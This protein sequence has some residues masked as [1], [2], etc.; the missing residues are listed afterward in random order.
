[1][2]HDLHLKIADFGLSERDYNLLL[3]GSRTAKSETTVQPIAWLPYEVLRNKDKVY[4]SDVWSFGVYMWEVFEFGYGNPYAHMK[5]QGTLE[6]D[7]LI[8][9][10][11]DGNRLAMPE[12]CPDEVFQLMK[13]CWELDPKQR[14][15]FQNL[16]ERLE[17]LAYKIAKKE[18]S[19]IYRQSQTETEYT[20]V[21]SPKSL[22]TQETQLSYAGLHKEFEW[23]EMNEKENN[24]EE[25][26]NYSEEKE[27]NPDSTLP[28]ICIHSPPSQSKKSTDPP[29]QPM[30]WATYLELKTK[31]G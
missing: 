9:F 10:L 8:K 4:A 31:K 19:L 15:S 18:I 26:K 3:P 22:G 7:K 27:N 29:T 17:F 11:E 30:S 13:E 14:P 24:P 20:S 12:L 21:S 2:T 5:D 28:V 6:L 16:K 23:F 1:M 25:N